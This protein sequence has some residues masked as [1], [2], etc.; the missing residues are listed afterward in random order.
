MK[1]INSIL[2]C[3]L[4]AAGVFFTQQATAQAP[5]K[6][7]YQSVIRNSSNA[8]LVNTAVGIKISVLQGSE[9]GTAVY[10]ETQTATT[11]ANGLV[12]IQIGTGTATTGTFAG[13][14]WSAGPYFIKTETDPAGGTNYTIT[15]TQE[16]LSVPYAMYAA[17][18][19]DAATTWSQN[20]N[21]GTVIGGSFIGTT[22]NVP[23]SIRVNNQLA[24]H[25]GYE[26]VE[27]STYLGYQAGN[28]YESINMNSTAIGYK[29]LYSNTSGS[30][31]TAIGTKAL[32]SNLDGYS[33]TAIGAGALLRNTSGHSNISI[34]PGTLSFNTTGVYN[35]ANGLNALFR[36]TTGARNV[37]NGYFSLRNNTTG[38]QNVAMGESSL[39]T[40]TTGT[41]NTALGS[42]ADVV[43]DALT[44]ATAIGFGAKVNASNTI[45]LGNSSVTDVNTS[46]TFT[47]AGFKTPLGTSSQ[48]LMADGS[49]SPRTTLGQV[50][51]TSTSN[52]G[53]I[54]SGVLS[55]TPA[56]A[57]NSG[58]V[59]PFNQTFG[60]A[61]TFAATPVLS[62]ATASQALFTDAN[63]NVVSNAITGSGNVVMSVSP[64]LTGTPS[65]PT[66][67]AGNNTTQ[68]ATT[69]FVTSSIA[70]SSLT[71]G[72]IGT[73]NAKGALITSTVLSLSPADATNGG[74]VTNGSQTIGGAKT[75]AQSVTA[76]SFVKTNGT[77][78]Q[79]LMA[80]G[81]TSAGQADAI[82]DL[83][84]Q[85]IAL[86]SQITAGQVAFPK[87]TTSEITTITSTTVNAGGSISSDGNATVTARGVCWST[88]ANPTIALTTKTT[89][90]T[91]TGVFSSAITGLTANT[92]YYVRAYATNSYG[93]G[94]GALVSFT[95]L[96]TVTTTVITSITATTAN[97][98][99]SISSDG[100]ATITARGV[101][102]STTSNPTIALTTKTT[103]GT[104]TGV[105]TSEITGLT[106]FT[107][108][109]VRAYATNS[110]GTSYGEEFSFS[111]LVVVA[112]SVT[113]SATTTIT[114]KT[115]NV[116]G[117]ISSDGNATVTAR[118]V[119]WSTTANP[120]IALTT[121]TTDGTGTGIFSNT[122]TGL[123]P[124]T[125]YY[126]RAYA[127][128][129]FGTSYGAQVSFT[130]LT[131]VAPT[132]TTSVTT[133]AVTTVNSGGSISSDGN[134]T[135]TARGVCWSTTTNPTIALATK[136]TDGT[137]TGV[138]T[139]AI[140]GLAA[141]T[142]YFV[143]AYATNSF[144]TGYGAQVSFTTSTVAILPSVTIVPPPDFFDQTPISWT[145]KNLDVS[146]YSD[147]TVIP[148]VT[149]PTAWVNLTT[150]AWCYYD[151]DSTNRA[152]Y[153]KL[154]NNY[155]VLGIYDDASLANPALRKQLA[156]MGWHVPTRQE[157]FDLRG[158][159]NLNSALDLREAG[160][161]NWFLSGGNNSSGFTG[162]PGGLRNT[163][164]QFF[165]KGTNALWW[166][167]TTLDIANAAYIFYILDYDNDAKLDLFPKIY[168]ASVRCIRD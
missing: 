129:S 33:N 34:G 75:F 79:Y 112:P 3:L 84:A 82:A 47:A 95:T 81:S 116:G 147:G 20:G 60:G 161:T 166:S 77:S 4:L 138:F 11:N 13:I 62:T 118:G 94:Y 17:K 157:W 53:T 45:Q 124:N 83:Q 76:N 139:S 21:A 148:Q 22:D 91:G 51:G 80:D 133:I 140:T 29:A 97:A 93:T 48:Y 120:T 101:C 40:N 1:K 102:W 104:G 18:S 32:Y 36:N 92:T 164:G 87:L 78:S 73:S 137:G 132:L 131:I 152:I 5:Q 38:T 158:M 142:T 127:T 135:V 108:Y 125:T 154:Y 54:T 96:P 107:T 168:G 6:M 28:W 10:V 55:L 153:G 143:R 68:L 19:G 58:I 2:T 67:T 42:E 88:T 99:G 7:S 35:T 103:N 16:M 25:I 123:T 85:I 162:L 115:A 119:C 121:K 126:V 37:A 155:A 165:T 100:N 117:S 12:S 8:L 114:A 110:Y 90:G 122:I 150:G 128:N 163:S 130:T 14:N 69:A 39:L 24:A 27:S 149:D 160:N 15:G 106:A 74:I 23:F 72:D 50:G 49:T 41:Q 156:P 43:T 26:E 105:F 57:T 61:K 9:S 44:N 146:T 151:N 141:N 30:N 98:G 46:G 89:D 113:T 86:R 144:G 59:T 71:M 66:A 145:T 65:A 70:A 167:S 31:N 63:K 64:T 136:T 159:M 56:D 134:A 109:Y 111:S 52:G